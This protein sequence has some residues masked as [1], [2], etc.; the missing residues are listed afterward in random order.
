MLTLVNCDAS[1]I[2][3]SLELHI[4]PTQWFSLFHDSP[5]NTRLRIRKKEQLWL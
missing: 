1:L 4:Q 3:Y 5:A 2:M